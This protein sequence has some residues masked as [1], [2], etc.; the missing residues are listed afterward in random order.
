MIF[1]SFDG[2]FAFDD[3]KRNEKKQAFIF[4][5]F[6]SLPLFFCVY[7]VNVLRQWNCTSWAYL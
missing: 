3:R 1:L 7:A 2:S 4:S 5:F 6:L